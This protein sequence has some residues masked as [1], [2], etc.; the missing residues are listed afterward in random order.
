[1]SPKQVCRFHPL[2]FL[3]V[4]DVVSLRPGQEQIGELQESNKYE[5]YKFFYDNLETNSLDII[6]TPRTGRVQIY[7]STEEEYPTKER[8]ERAGTY[9][10]SSAM[11]HYDNPFHGK[12]YYIGVYSET[13]SNYSII[14]TTGNRKYTN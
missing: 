14:A 12:T 11:V 13:P 6:A 1:M 8:H 10:S 4:L 3:T 7:V 2:R 9:V 5:Y